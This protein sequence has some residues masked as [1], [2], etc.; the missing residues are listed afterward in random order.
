MNEAMVRLVHRFPW[1][2][3]RGKSTGLDI[4]VGSGLAGGGL[5]DLA[6]YTGIDRL[7]SWSAS[8]HYLRHLYLLLHCSSQSK[9]RI[10]LTLAAY[11]LIPPNDHYS[12][13]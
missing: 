6:M 7:G 13:R 8:S 1:D 12:P 5:W 10:T 9:D 4:H 11:I 2:R 3:M